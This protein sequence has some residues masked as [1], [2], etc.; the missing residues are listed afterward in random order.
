MNHAVFWT[1]DGLPVI[2]AG[3]VKLA[4]DGQT[5]IIF[6]GYELGAGGAVRP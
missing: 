4:F 3:N 2:L 5:F 6:D 1:K